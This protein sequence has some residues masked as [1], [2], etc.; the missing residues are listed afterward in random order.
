MDHDLWVDDAPHGL[1]GD[2]YFVSC[3]CGWEYEDGDEI[4][5]DHFVDEIFAAHVSESA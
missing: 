3:S 5:H 1:P 4:V 2:F